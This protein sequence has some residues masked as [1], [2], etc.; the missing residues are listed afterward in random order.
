MSRLPFSREPD[1]GLGIAF[2]TFFDDDEVTNSKE[3]RA[4][5]LK[6]FP[7]TFVPYAESLT[8]D[9][10]TVYDFV[11][12]INKGVQ[13]LSSKELKAEDKAAWAKA[14]EYLD[15]RPF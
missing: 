2:R 7:A 14:Q 15:A 3:T 5:R 9:F 8:E 10:Q 13:T 1:I 11:D 4:S 12:A 6:E